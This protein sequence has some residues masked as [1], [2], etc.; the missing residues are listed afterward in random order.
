[1]IKNPIEEQMLIIVQE[2][3]IGLLERKKIIPKKKGN[4]SKE[5]PLVCYECGKVGHMRNEC[6]LK[7]MINNLN[8]D[9][10]LKR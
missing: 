2:S 1:M 5:K 7:D 10:G 6:K 3:F 8:L 9:K 4:S